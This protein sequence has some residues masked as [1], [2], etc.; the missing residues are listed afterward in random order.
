MRDSTCAHFSN[1]HFKVTR[2]CYT[3]LF[4]WIQNECQLRVCKQF[5]G[6]GTAESQNRADLSQLHA[7]H[8][9]S[10]WLTRLMVA[11]VS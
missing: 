8:P 11:V 3:V 10:L 4:V 7:V 9:A 2:T 6:T 5:A 1:S